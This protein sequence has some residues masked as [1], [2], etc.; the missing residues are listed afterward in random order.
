MA[1]SKSA[2]APLT[3]AAIRP[4]VFAPA[5]KD[6]H[7]CGSGIGLDIRVEALRHD[8]LQFCLGV[9][10]TSYFGNMSE[11]FVCKSAAQMRATDTSHDVEICSRAFA[12]RSDFRWSDCQAA[13]LGAPLC[14]EPMRE[15]SRSLDQRG[16]D[17]PT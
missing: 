1:I 7:E 6:S 4:V 12:S 17:V 3:Q 5:R 13:E 16:G 14:E 2:A 8:R 9:A 15:T 11:A 10:N